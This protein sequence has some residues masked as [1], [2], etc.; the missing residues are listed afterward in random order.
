MD[1][2]ILLIAI[3]LASLAPSQGARAA[4]WC[5]GTISA[6]W[7]SA[8]GDVYL[9]GSWVGTHTRI[10][11]LDSTW[12]GITPSVCA[13]WMAKI[14]AAISTSRQVTVYY[15]SI[16]DCSTIPSYTNAPAPWYVML[17]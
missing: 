10:C 3:M 6:S 13:S 17:L 4:A 9:L 14:D 16:S 15:D 12:S 11:N 1:R 8:G 5:T 2:K 7:V